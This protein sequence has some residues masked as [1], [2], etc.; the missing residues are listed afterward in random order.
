MEATAA[1]VIMGAIDA[2]MMETFAAKEF[3]PKMVQRAMAM[4]GAKMSFTTSATLKGNISSFGSLKR[5]PSPTA[6]SASG[7]MVLE[8]ETS[9]LS[10]MGGKTVPIKK[11]AARS[12][13]K[14]GKEMILSKRSRICISFALA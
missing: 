4:M 8:S 7:M 1:A 10:M 14:G 12:A 2:S 6:T 9:T 5:S 13:K 3:Q 11:S